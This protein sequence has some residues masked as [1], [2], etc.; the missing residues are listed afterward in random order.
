MLKI[1]DIPDIGPAEFVNGLVI[2]SYHAQVLIFGSQQPDKVK[3][4]RVRVLIL[5][6][7]N[8]PEPLLVIIQHFLIGLEQLHGFHNQVIKIQRIVSAQHLLIFRIYIRNPLPG[9]VPCGLLPVKG[10]VQQFVLGVRNC[11]QKK[12]F[13]VKLCIDFKTLA[14]ILHQLFLVVC[15]IY[16]KIR[17]ISNPVDMPP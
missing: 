6:H 15:I 16:R 2:I 14:D 3:L 4:R 5:V 10:R 1:Q 9:I 12:L 11:I 17:V 8:I 13:F 7:H